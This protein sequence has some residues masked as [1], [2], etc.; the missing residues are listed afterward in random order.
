MS[1]DYRRAFARAVPASARAQKTRA[2]ARLAEA[3]EAR[4]RPPL[5]E[6]TFAGGSLADGLRRGLLW[7]ESA[8]PAR[9]ELVIVSTLAIGSITQADLAAI[10]QSAGVRFER[11][12]TLPASR[13]VKR[14]EKIATPTP[15]TMDV[16]HGVWNRGWTA[17]TNGGSRPSRAML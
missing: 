17:L 1:R 15:V 3:P 10:P 4:R 5:R 6:E 7:L 11:A 14:A 2:T 9:R 13:T 12:G 16:N 8:P